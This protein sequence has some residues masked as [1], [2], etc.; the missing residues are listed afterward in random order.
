M[1]LFMNLSIFTCLLLA[2][3]CLLEG[4]NFSKVVLDRLHVVN[5]AQ[6]SI[7]IKFEC[8]R[9]NGQ[10]SQ[11]VI[12]NRNVLLKPKEAKI[13]ILPPGSTGNGYAAGFIKAAHAIEERSGKP[14]YFHVYNN[15]KGETTCYMHDHTLGFD[16]FQVNFDKAIDSSSSS[17][18]DCIHN[19]DRLY[20]NGVPS[21]HYGALIYPAKPIDFIMHMRRLYNTYYPDNPSEII[22]PD[23]KNRIPKII[24]QI[25]LG[26]KPIPMSYLEYQKKWQLFHPEWKYRL[27]T[28]KDIAPF[29]L[30][31]KKIFDRAPN[32]TSKAD[33]LRLEILSR[34]GGVYVD[35]DTEPCEPLDGL[36]HTFDFFAL[37]NGPNQGILLADV[38]FIGS[39]PKHPVIE[40]AI[41]NIAFYHTYPPHEYLKLAPN[42][43]VGDTMVFGCLSFSRAVI[44][45][46]GKSN[47]RDILLPYYYFGL[48]QVNICSYGIHYQ[49]LQ[50][51]KNS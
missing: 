17:Y 9:W 2:W 24:H 42:K 23:K 13:F 21:Q 25:W 1:A 27:W 20:A 11:Y 4:I 35:F 45:K 40:Q 38:Y 46:A 15:K 32:Y 22:K 16:I 36:V 14:A 34:Y 31:N 41:K 19:I 7:V 5:N 49:K 44:E 50:W 26:P 3:S 37:L 28:D 47:L 43:N 18:Y 33:I 8:Y 30:R 10:S 12:E 29:K 6:K 48:Y 51:I 39:I